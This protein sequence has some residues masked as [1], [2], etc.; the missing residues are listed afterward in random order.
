MTWFSETLHPGYCQHL[1]IGHVVFEDKTEHQHLILFDNPIFGRV[2]AL[3]GIVQTTERDEFFYHEML[4]HVPLVAHGAAQ[5]VLIIGGGDGGSLREVLRHPVEHATLVELDRTVIDLCTEHLPGLSQGAFDD[6][7]TQV[8]IGNGG[9]FMA[10]TEQKFDVIIVDSTDPMGPGEALF[11]QA[12]YGDCKRC[13]SPGGVLV[14][15]NGVP[16]FQADELTR[17]G[18]RLRQ[19][20]SDVGFY[21]VPVPTYV[22]GPMT[23]GFS[24]DNPDLHRLGTDVLA[25]RFAALEITTRYYTPHVHRAAFDLPGYITALIP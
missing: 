5:N 9:R 21:T 13:L 1:E 16:F 19:E 22:G 2:L 23:L 18:R 14:T 4:V 7:R 17:A 8:H 24:T 3:D 6:P 12:F 15:Q 20:F 10:D 11:T 25:A